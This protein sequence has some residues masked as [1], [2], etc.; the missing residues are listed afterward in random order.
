[1][2]ATGYGQA[3][4]ALTGVSESAWDELRMTAMHSL[5]VFDTAIDADAFARSC[6]EWGVDTPCVNP[7]FLEDERMTR[8]LAGQGL[9]PWLNVPVF[10][11][12]KYLE[13]HPQAYAVTNLGRRAAQD[14]LHFVCPSRDDY[15]DGVIDGLRRHLARLSPAVV[16]LDFI[17]HFVFWERIALAGPSAGIEDGCY[18]PV[19]LSRF[20]KACGQLVER[21]DAPGYIHRHLLQSW[22]DWKCRRI[23]EVTER[24]VAELR[25]LAPGVAVAVQTIPWAQA[26]LD[27]AVRSRAGQDIPWL[28]RHVDLVAPMAFTQ[29]LGQTARWKEKL[30]AHVRAS[31]GK[32][33]CFYVQADALDRAGTITVE[34][35]D[36]ELSHARNGDHAAIVVLQY[37]HLAARPE[38]A[39]VL[40]RHF[41]P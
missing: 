15:I 22:A 20:E 27:G 14:W 36:A 1:M 23:L 32:P 13:Q 4:M 3:L 7:D 18:C 33:V 41:R 11:N 6:R 17:R 29:M 12:P 35:F 8:A 34:Q 31:T 37:E 24:I 9:R 28:A 25:A 30:L 38:M 2:S 16:S 40:R 5:M 39:A 21:K 19:C 10:C 26:D